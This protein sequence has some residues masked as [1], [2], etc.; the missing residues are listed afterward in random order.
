[1]KESPLGH[2]VA[3]IQRPSACYA[4]GADRTGSR[5]KGKLFPINRRYCGEL[6]PSPNKRNITWT[7]PNFH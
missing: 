6:R 2:G 7:F 5:A 4:G 3:F 1:M